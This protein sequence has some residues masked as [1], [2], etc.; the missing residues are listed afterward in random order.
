MAIWKVSLISAVTFIALLL[1][2]SLIAIIWHRAVDHGAY[3]GSALMHAHRMRGI[4]FA[5]H[6]AA[7]CARLDDA[8]INT[9]AEVA[10][11]WVERQMDLSDVQRAAL[12]PL[13]DVAGDWAR[14]L[15]R[16]CRVPHGD[17]RTA[18]SLVADV[19]EVT[20]NATQQIKV[21]FTAFYDTLD[22]AQRSELDALAASHFQRR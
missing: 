18:V 22:V 11:L 10:T 20:R 5:G 14:E 4:A 13:V 9:Y 6:G 17:A 16:L 12:L 19:A 1:V 8:T 2:L 21:G 15:E 7:G 3:A